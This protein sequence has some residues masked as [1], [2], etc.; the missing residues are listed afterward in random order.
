MGDLEKRFLAL[1]T[2]I[3]ASLFLAYGVRSL[4]IG[5]SSPL[6]M[7]VEGLLAAAIGLFG[8]W[9]LSNGAPLVPTVLLVSLIH[10]GIRLGEPM[11]SGLT[12]SHMQPLFV[13]VLFLGGLVLTSVWFLVSRLIA[14]SIVGARA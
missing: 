14:N 7:L 12:D 11:F 2:S 6:W 1:G 13:F 9:R 8:F 4:V 10:V 3:Y 5:V